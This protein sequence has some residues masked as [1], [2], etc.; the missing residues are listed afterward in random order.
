MLFGAPDGAGFD[1]FVDGLV[2]AR[3]AHPC[4]IDRDRPY[5]AAPF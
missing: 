1:Q 2:D 3:H 5:Q 4:D